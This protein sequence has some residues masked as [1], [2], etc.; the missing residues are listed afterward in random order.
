MRALIVD[1]EL[2]AREELASLLASNQRVA[3]LPRAS[4]RRNA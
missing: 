2:H 3:S 1:D 4:S